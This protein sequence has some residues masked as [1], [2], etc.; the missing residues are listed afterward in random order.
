M[1]FHGSLAL[2]RNFVGAKTSIEHSTASNILEFA[3]DC[4]KDF[5]IP[6]AHIECEFVKPS[7]DFIALLKFL[8]SFNRNKFNL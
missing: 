5:Q 6:Y 3:A 4:N 8:S 1:Y 7:C 2:M